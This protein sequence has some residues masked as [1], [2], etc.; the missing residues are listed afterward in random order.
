MIGN[1]ARLNRAVPEG[2]ERAV[3]HVI[4]YV[5]WGGREGSEGGKEAWFRTI[6]IAVG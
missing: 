2:E 4:G 1:G 3:W 5:L 6:D